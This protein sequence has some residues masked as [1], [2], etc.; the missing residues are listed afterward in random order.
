[1]MFPNSFS[2]VGMNRRQFT[3]ALGIGAVTLATRRMTV[4]VSK[5]TPQIS[6]T[7]DDFHWGNV[8]KLS[9][10]ERNQAILSTLNTNRIKAALFVVGRNIESEEGKQLLREWDKAGHLICNHTYSH[11]NYANPQMTATAYGEDIL[12]AESL[13]KEFPRF[14]KYFRYPMLKEGE[15]VAKRDQLRT[16]LSNHGYRMGYVT[17]DDSDWLVDQRLTARLQNEPTADIKPYRDFYL[18]HMW[19]RAQYYDSLA[20]RVLGRPVPHTL[21]THFNLLNALFLNDLIEM[22]K[23]KGWEWIDAE[24]AFTDPVFSKLPSI[25]PAGESIVWAIAKENGAIAKSLRYPAEDG[26]SEAARMKKLGL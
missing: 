23:H 17:I 7:M 15:S 6:L 14:R 25:I 2:G 26:E 20:R 3:K 12:R 1:M 18:G 16:F 4:S 10:S 5:T 8:V 22:F 19:D 24:K 9:G 11:R 21:L 13:L